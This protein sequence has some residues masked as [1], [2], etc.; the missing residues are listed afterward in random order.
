MAFIGDNVSASIDIQK[1]IFMTNHY[2]HKIATVIFMA[3]RSL[4]DLSIG[5]LE[6]RRALFNKISL[7]MVGIIVGYGVLM[8]L[9][10]YNGTW[11]SKS[12]IIVLPWVILAIMLLINQLKKRTIVEIERRHSE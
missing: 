1:L 5:E 3:Y 4:K 7:F 11:E 10:M 12:Y 8:A 9:R 2:H 6:K